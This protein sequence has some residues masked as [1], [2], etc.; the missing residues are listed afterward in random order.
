MSL[1]SRSILFVVVVL[2]IL[3]QIVSQSSKCNLV[4]P[5]SVSCR[6]EPSFRCGCSIGQ[7]NCTKSTNV[8]NGRGVCS[9]I[10]PSHC[11]RCISCSAQ[12]ICDIGY[13][14]SSCQFP[15]CNGTISTDPQVCSGRGSCTSYNT[16]SCSSNYVGTFCEF[17][18]CF[19]FN[20]TNVNVCSGNGICTSPNTCSCNSGWTGNQ[21][22]LPICNG[23]NSTDPTVCSSKGTC[24]SPNNC[25]CSSG[26][27]GVNCQFP[28]CFGLN[29]TDPNV[30]SGNGTCISLDQCQCKSS[31]SGNQCQVS[32]S[33]YGRNQTDPLVCSGNGICLGSDNCTCNTNWVGPN[34]QFPLCNGT[35]ANQTNVCSGNGI[36]SAVNNCTCNSGYTGALCQYPICSGKN[37]TDSSVCSGNGNCTSAN[38]C[39]C[40]TNIF[41]NNCQYYQFHFKNSS[42]FWSN[43]S[44]WYILTN[45][46]QTAPRN[47]SNSDQVYVDL[48]GNY[49]I[50]I[51]QT[52]TLA[53]L[54]IGCNNSC[55]ITLF[56]NNN[57]DFQGSV[58]I[59][60]G[61]TLSLYRGGI[62]N[63]NGPT[64][65]LSTLVSYGESILNF[66]DTAII[67]SLNYDSDVFNFYSDV[68]FSGDA[69][70]N[71]NNF[72]FSKTVTMA[73]T[74]LL[75]FNSGST[76]FTQ[77]LYINQNASLVLNGYV[78]FNN[79]TITGA[80]PF[81]GTGG[82]TINGNFIQNSS[83]QFPTVYLNIAG[84]A[85][86]SN[87]YATLSSFTVLPNSI[88]NVDNYSTLEITGSSNIQSNINGAGL[89]Y[90]NGG[91][92]T[93]SGNVN[94]ST[95][96]QSNSL[97]QVS[98]N[99][100]INFL[101]NV[102]FISNFTLMIPSNS[103][104]NVFTGSALLNNNQI[105]GTG[106]FGINNGGN[107]LLNATNTSF[108][109]VIILSSGNFDLYGSFIFNQPVQF[110]SSSSI[111]ITNT[112][113]I[114]FNNVFNWIISQDV[115]GG[116]SIIIGQN[117][118]LL[119]SCNSNNNID[120]S[121]TTSSTSIFT[122]S[123]NLLNSVTFNDL[124]Q[125]IV[126]SGTLNFK[127]YITINSNNLM[128]GTGSI[129]FYDTS[130]I[131][132]SSTQF[133][134]DL[135][136]TLRSSMN[137]ITPFNILSNGIITFTSNLLLSGFAQI[138]I[139]S[140]VI[141]L[142]Q[143]TSTF[144]SQNAITGNG[145][146]RIQTPGTLSWNNG[147]TIPVF[148]D[149]QSDLSLNNGN[150]IIN[151]LLSITV[152]SKFTLQNSQVSVFS[153]FTLTT[154]EGLFGN[155][156]LIQES[157]SYFSW[158]SGNSNGVSLLLNGPVSISDLDKTFT[159]T[160]ITFFGNVN[161]NSKVNLQNT[162]I[163]IYSPIFTHNSGSFIGT[164]LISNYGIYT[165][166]T[167]IGTSASLLTS[168]N[169]FATLNISGD[170]AF[171]LSPLYNQFP[172]ATLTIN[173]TVVFCSGTLSINNG[174]F[175]VG[176]TLKSSLNITTS[177]IAYI[178]SSLKIDGNFLLDKKSSMF[179]D[180]QGANGPFIYPIFVGGYTNLAGFI[181]IRL[182]NGYDPQVGDKIYF[183]SLSQSFQNNNTITSE[184]NMIGASYRNAMFLISN[185]DVVITIIT[186]LGS[187][188]NSFICDFLGKSK[189]IEYRI[190][191]QSSM[192]SIAFTLPPYSQNKPILL[193]L[194]NNT[195]DQIPILISSFNGTITTLKGQLFDSA[196]SSLQSL[197][198]V[199]P[200]YLTINI[201]I[202]T[203]YL[204][205]QNKILYGETVNN[206]LVYQE[207][208]DFQI[209][210]PN[211]IDCTNVDIPTR[212]ETYTYYSL[213]A[214]LIMYIVTF[215]ACLILI[216]L[217]PLHS[218]KLSPLIA[219]IFLF[220]QLALEIKNYFF[221]DIQQS[222]C[223]Y[224]GYGYLP[225]TQ[226]QFLLIF[227]YFLYNISYI[228]LNY[229]KN[230]IILGKSFEKSIRMMWLRFITRIWIIYLF[231]FI[232]FIVMYIVNSVILAVDLYICRFKT[233]LTLKIINSIV[234]IVF[235][236][237]SLG[238]VVLDLIFSWKTIVKCHWINY[239]F[240]KD[241][242]FIRVQIYAFVPFLIYSIIAQLYIFSNSFYFK[243]VV[244]TFD[245]TLILNTITY[246][247]VYIIEI[248]FPL[249]C[250]FIVFLFRYF[251]R[252]AK[253]DPIL[254]TLNNPKIY[255]LFQQF[256]IN[257]F[258]AENIIC[259]R[260]I[261]AYKIAEDKKKVA[262]QIFQKFLRGPH[263]YLMLIY[264]P[265]DIVEAIK[266][267]IQSDMCEIDLFSQLEEHLLKNLE[268]T[269]DRFLY[270]DVYVLYK[271][272][273]E[274]DSELKPILNVNVQ[275]NNNS[276]NNSDVKIINGE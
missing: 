67:A 270:S 56:I 168:F 37:S 105:Y 184:V 26:Y 199:G 114:T 129:V 41:G 9:F 197:F 160:N 62:L 42:G 198:N 274:V 205:Y 46:Y 14:G 27:S 204:Q 139:P 117:G 215:I 262:I 227:T 92:I 214:I 54:S 238:L 108:I 250:T 156:L 13:V 66:K 268:S 20:S 241:P 210:N 125:V 119:W 247:L 12:C 28:T 132:I 98:T 134:F 90:L 24:S 229:K 110:T 82:L 124:S 240:Y 266:E 226:M 49:T 80:S 195:L 60:P 25:T 32:N 121:I 228:H 246:N 179:I 141:V 157:S 116:G 15:T 248:L 180:I 234:I 78:N 219:L 202:D 177:G 152:D 8:C 209:T 7:V 182:R 188:D 19:G 267:K 263:T 93:F 122:G 50:T 95:N 258:N 10:S 130:S 239:I 264:C 127:N 150:F 76:S 40:N 212:A 276:E 71:V 86:F 275:Q 128:N 223:L 107:F 1:C 172:S 96:L 97:I 111:N 72:V 218:R 87:A 236:A 52:I 135:P 31:Y 208:F 44:S 4:C 39:I 171:F 231:L 187:I 5:G 69:I 217:Q 243:D 259:W 146:L 200:N 34:C 74:S 251:K 256:C 91:N 237:M 272:G 94:I 158:T 193:G 273:V 151:N 163:L 102:N 155:G 181:S 55:F 185:T 138:N 249:I 83:V 189:T 261:Q 115:Y 6:G 23:K 58:Y 43:A 190:F 149:V 109:D 70:V 253:K 194:V 144:S 216:R 53:Q 38:T 252:P 30:C 143:G 220:L 104:F 235:N 257:E 271:E 106:T 118:T 153:N 260:E 99:S 225:F 101:N 100:S 61:V 65:I 22:Q 85:F 159:N 51:D 186:S 173:N 126:N 64:Q 162:F 224:Y 36:C 48:P 211:I 47:P 142:L 206:T 174:N 17:P 169:N 222:L 161:L 113:L 165:S 178:I 45:Q 244:L 2:T 176:G 192:I 221:I 230:Q 154:T 137:I 245:K 201:L 73:G 148:L 140:N 242:F 191:N 88:I 207:I 254:V 89:I 11:H 175:L 75:V 233:F 79:V 3:Q 269:Y 164:G 183:I 33:C 131:S 35:S 81:S 16:C 232:S 103:S 123:M 170:G 203:K 133:N 145:A 136:V 18:V 29:S 196:V 77:D 57:I 63:F 255:R 68:T 21:C 213:G 167:F 166:T 147:A 59:S 120:L 84:N 265:F 112:T